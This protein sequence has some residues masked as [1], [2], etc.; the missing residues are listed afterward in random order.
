MTAAPPT[1][2]IGDTVGLSFDV[3]IVSGFADSAMAE[4]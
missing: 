4:K 1:V 2:A 3:A